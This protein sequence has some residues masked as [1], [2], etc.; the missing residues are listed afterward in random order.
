[1]VKKD[2][3]IYRSKK[4]KNISLMNLFSLFIELRVTLTLSEFPSLSKPLFF[5]PAPIFN[6]GRRTSLSN[7]S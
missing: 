6:F 2:T 4:N 1:M 7:S 5:T 3:S